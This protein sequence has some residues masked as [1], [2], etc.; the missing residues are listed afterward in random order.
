MFDFSQ[1]R[2]KS[3]PDSYLHKEIDIVA[4]NVSKRYKVL[5]IDF[6]HDE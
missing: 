1:I 4:M 5:N 3:I 6:Y 2:Q